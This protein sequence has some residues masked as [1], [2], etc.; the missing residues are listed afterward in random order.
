MVINK[1]KRQIQLEALKA[2]KD[3]N[4]TGTIILPTGSG[5][6]WILTQ[7]I[8]K[9]KPKRC[10][11]LCDSELN[12]D[13]TFR[14]ELI[15]WGMK[16]W[17]DKIE[18][19]CYQSAYKLKGEHYDLALFDEADYMCTPQYFKFA[20]NNKF[21]HPVLVSATAEDKKRKLLEK[22][23]PIVYEMEIQEAEDSGALTAVNYF[24]VPFDLQA[25]E[26]RVYVN[27]NEKFQKI[28]F[29]EKPNRKALNFLALQRSHFL[30]N[31]K[32]S[33]I[34]CRKLLRYINDNTPDARALIFCGT[35]NQADKVCKYSYHGGNVKEDSL[36][37]FNSGDVN[38][39]SV[40]GKID[41][42][43][44]LN[45][46]NVV[47]FEK[48]TRSITKFTQ[49]SGRGKRLAKDLK[50]DVYFLLPYYLTRFGLRKQT[51]VQ[52]WIREATSK[53]DITNI[54]TITL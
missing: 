25:S 43:V 2:I 7:I 45:G 21:D 11:Y 18:Y 3:A 29:H 17:V 46:V 52:D 54:K 50:L 47:V 48:M 15:E 1:A 31:L 53:V 14:N 35:Q 23:A 22:V 16:D 42:G 19:I 27:Y 20:K 5:K 40:V 32:S 9:L 4:Y 12:R 26:N 49:K 41:R 30:S 33:L 10:I 6:G 51:I 37:K 44:N 38:Y 34:T 36:V 28:L 39:L 13:T 8:K 24:V